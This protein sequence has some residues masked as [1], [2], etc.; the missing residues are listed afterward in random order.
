VRY[1]KVVIKWRTVSI[2]R[3]FLRTNPL[4]RIGFCF[5]IL[6]EGHDRKGRGNTPHDTRIS[7]NDTFVVCRP[8]D[9]QS[10][11]YYCNA[12]LHAKFSKKRDFMFLERR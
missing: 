6:R 7:I 3:M 4:Q 1:K 11:K 8:E 10:Y 2:C 9:K 12:N 5:C